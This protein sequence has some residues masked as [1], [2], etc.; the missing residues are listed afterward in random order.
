MKSKY[1]YLLLAVTLGLF[2]AASAFT[3]E[4]PAQ[5]PA[6]N[7]SVIKFSHQLHAEITDCESCHSSAT[8]A[9]TLNDPL[10]PTMDD[11]AACH[12]VEDDE[13]CSMCHYE[14]NYEP[15]EQSVNQEIYFDHSFHT[16]DQDME[17]TD[18]HQGMEEVDYGY[19]SFGANPSMETC[20]TCHN[21]KS[22]ASMNCESCH[23]STVGLVPSDHRTA[24]FFENHKFSSQEIDANCYMCHDDSFCEDCHVATT[25]MTETNTKTDFYTPYSPHNYIDNTVKQQI[26]RVHE[27]NY[28]FTHGIDAKEGATE[29]QTCHEVQTFCAEC[30]NVMGGDFAIGGFVP[31]SHTVDDFV[32]IG[33]GTGGGEHALL[34]K[35]EIES[36]AA[37]HDTQG[38]DPNC[39]LCHV[40]PDGIEGT[41]PKTHL[42]NFKHNFDD[43]DWHS[44]FNSVCYNCHTDA[45]ARPDGQRGMLFCGY[46]HN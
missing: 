39:I 21:N 40:D 38:A 42:T 18:C 13:N 25:A 24:R 31:Y 35:R 1:F 46:C 12:D 10:L 7:K 34:A 15:F 27:F 2:L 28:R 26:N 9:V 8:E 3:S 14:E 41:N 17:C 30:H 33:V 36:C 6:D 23:V 16:G 37:C 44:D 20:S 45:N 4:T 11:C 29:C 22:V 5:S 32:S 19:E 43:G